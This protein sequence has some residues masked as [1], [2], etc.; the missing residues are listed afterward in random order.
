MAYPLA[1][2]AEEQVVG[3]RA[4][5]ERRRRRAERDPE[6]ILRELAALSPGAPVVHEEYG[7]GRSR[8]LKV[9]QVAG[10]PAEFLVIEYAG[11]PTVLA[12]TLVPGAIM[13][14][15]GAIISFK[16]INVPRSSQHGV[17]NQ[18]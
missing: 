9:M 10:N 18:I 1:L 14:M 13:G 17:G 6:A 8:G 15:I 7:V 2:V 11:M 12:I 5:Q 4:R 16:I 3:E